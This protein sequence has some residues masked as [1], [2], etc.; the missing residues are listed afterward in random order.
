MIKEKNKYNYSHRDEKDDESR[1][2]GVVSGL[3]L[4]TIGLISVAPLLAKKG[5]TVSNEK[6]F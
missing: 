5:N 4:I 6:I 3:L 1:F 2:T